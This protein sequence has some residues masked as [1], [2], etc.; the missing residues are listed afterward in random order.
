MDVDEFKSILK[1]NQIVF[2]SKPN[3]KLCDD[4]SLYLDLNNIKY[5]KVNIN[6]I[7]YGVELVEDIKSKY[8]V[9]SFPICFK[10]SQYIGTK[11]DLIQDI[12]NT[13][14]NDINNI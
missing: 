8:D 10:D 14:Y 13:K 1:S 4:L 7:E 11:H 9:Q 5:N 2:L 3:C 6:V 12:L